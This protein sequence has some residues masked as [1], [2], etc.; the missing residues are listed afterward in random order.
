MDG[1]NWTEILSD[2]WFGASDPYTGR[3][4]N[5][6]WE[7]SYVPT[8]T[9]EFFGQ[10]NIQEDVTFFPSEE[11]DW[12]KFSDAHISSPYGLL[13]SPWNYNP[14]N[15][16]VRYHNVHRIASASEI[17]RG[18]FMHYS[19]IDCSIVSEFVSEVK[20][21]DIEA[22]LNYVEDDVHAL[23]HFTFG[24]HGGSHAAAVIQQLRSD[25]GFDDDDVVLL[26][27]AA[28]TFFKQHIEAASAK[29]LPIVCSDAPWQDFELTTTALPGD[30]GGPTCAFADQYMSDETYVDELITDFFSSVP[31][32]DAADKLKALDYVD[33]AAAMK[34]IGGMFQFDADMDGS[35]G[36]KNC[37]H[38]DVI[39]LL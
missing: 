7:S 24:G 30:E 36:R 19:G 23:I 2:K 14:A 11:D 5:S 25:Y 21:E 34:L 3:I 1:G 10:E 6:R 4:I 27:Q 13:R 22:F 18:I 26:A 39:V 20:G 9:H 15:Y 12:L 38:Y 37:V 35:G 17:D 16:T 32:T 28:Q 33:K 8:T 31:S 29:K